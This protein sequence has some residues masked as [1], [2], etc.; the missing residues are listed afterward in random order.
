MELDGVSEPAHDGVAHSRPVASEV[1]CEDRGR[2]VEWGLL[3]QRQEPPFGEILA[4]SEQHVDRRIAHRPRPAPSWWSR[5]HL[6]LL[7]RPH[8]VDDVRQPMSRKW[9][10][11]PES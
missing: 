10:P 7:S 5:L 11:W 9:T 1:R 2:V 8:V 4:A 6:R 3:E